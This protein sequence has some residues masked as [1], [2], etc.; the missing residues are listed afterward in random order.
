MP[1]R[2]VA[3]GPVARALQEIPLPHRV[4][5]NSARSRYGAGAMPVGLERGHGTDGRYE[6]WVRLL[7]AGLGAGDQELHG[8][9]GADEGSGAHRVGFFAGDFQ[10]LLPEG[11]ELVF[12]A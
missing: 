10:G 12:G 7:G 6:D 11:V 5:S 1:L 2:A 8:A 4:T 9:A 3:G